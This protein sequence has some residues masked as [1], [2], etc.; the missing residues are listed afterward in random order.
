MY[1]TSK[2]SRSPD[3]SMQRLSLE[4]NSGFRRLNKPKRQ[5]S[6]KRRTSPVRRQ[7][8]PIRKTP[9][10]RTPSKYFQRNFNTGSNR[11]DYNPEFLNRKNFRN[12]QSEESPF[13][14]NT[15]RN[16]KNRKPKQIWSTT[17][18]YSG[19]PVDSDSD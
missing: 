9:I 6:P 18:R 12:Y 4:D 10:Q 5:S 1:P 16:I 11:A 8:S 15:P 7:T 2:R 19:F 14:A 17:D 3:L 13:I